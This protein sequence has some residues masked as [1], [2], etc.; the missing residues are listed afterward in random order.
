MI[1]ERCGVLSQG[2]SGRI[3][4]VSFAR[5]TARRQ[6]CDDFAERKR[7]DAEWEYSVSIDFF[8]DV[9]PDP[10]TLNGVPISNTV[11]GE[12][13]NNFACSSHLDTLSVKCGATRC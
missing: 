1:C 5:T 9:I 3:S 7:L 12:L 13:R 11:V 8:H 2:K 10:Q 4:V 6:K